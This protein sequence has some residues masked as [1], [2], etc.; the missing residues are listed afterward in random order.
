[1]KYLEIINERIDTE[2]V[3][4]L[5]SNCIGM[6]YDKIIE[7][8]IEIGTKQFIEF[9]NE[10]AENILE[11]NL[12]EYL[13]KNFPISDGD[14]TVIP[15]ERYIFRVEKEN[16]DGYDGSCSMSKSNNKW[17]VN[18]DLG[19]ENKFFSK[20]FWLNP[21][22]N[23]FVDSALKILWHEFVHYIQ[24]QRQGTKWIKNWENENATNKSYASKLTRSFN[25][26]EMTYYLQQI[27][28]KAYA[29]TIVVDL[30]NFFNK[31]EIIK[32]IKTENGIDELCEHSRNL[33]YYYG[34]YRLYKMNDYR[35][36]S[37]S[38]IKKAKISKKIWS[39][40]VNQ[41]LI[42]LNNI[43]DNDIKNF[44]VDYKPAE[45]FLSKIKKIF[46]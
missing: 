46:Q 17:F 33:K 14:S 24:I 11:Q 37:I 31:D 19:I 13:Y 44:A 38:K 29:T 8:D 20:R 16:V 35:F 43:K 40:L 6:V 27:E 2:D 28:I 32:K 22:K 10:T 3:R 25:Y 4:Q 42:H 15:P 45:T 18:I 5:T 9:V 7:T 21:N 26:G 12:S 1:M 30:L 39:M 23:E 41:I 36:Q 34:I